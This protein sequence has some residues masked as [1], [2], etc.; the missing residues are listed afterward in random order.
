MVVIET[1]ENPTRT[2]T[3]KPLDFLSNIKC[4]TNDDRFSVSQ[5][6]SFHLFGKWTT[7]IGS[8]TDT[9]R[10]TSVKIHRLTLS[11]PSERRRELVKQVNWVPST[12]DYIV[13]TTTGTLAG[14][15]RQPCTCVLYICNRCNTDTWYI[16]DQYFTNLCRVGGSQSRGAPSIDYRDRQKTKE[17]CVKTFVEKYDMVTDPSGEGHSVKREMTVQVEQWW[18][19]SDL[20]ASLRLENVWD[21]DTG[22]SCCGRKTQK[23]HSCWRVYTEH[24]HKRWSTRHRCLTTVPTCRSEREGM[25]RTMKGKIHPPPTSTIVT[26]LRCASGFMT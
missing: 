13:T 14:G 26:G 7:H 25:M 24:Q 18:N 12:S 23:M 4:R 16:L 1:G 19:S 2:L 10:E 5:W 15:L 8:N 6:E 11:F 17:V 3:W 21:T 22:Y 9:V 20:V